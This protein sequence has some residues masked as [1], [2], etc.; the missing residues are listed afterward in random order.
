LDGMGYSQED[1]RSGICRL[2]GQMPLTDFAPTEVC[3]EVIET[4]PLGDGIVKE[5]IAYDGDP[6][7][8]ITAYLLRPE[9]VQSSRPAVIV[10]HGHGPYAIGKSS[11]VSEGRTEH[12][13]AFGLVRRGFVVLAPDFLC[14]EDRSCGDPT[15]Y[16]S[17]QA[18]ALNLFLKGRSL[19]G[20]WVWDA[21]RGVSALSAMPYVDAARIGSIGH[22]MGG[23]TTILLMAVDGR[24][25]A[26]VTSC[27]FS[28]WDALFAAGR[29]FAWA[30]RMP[31][32]AL[33]HNQQQSPPSWA[34]IIG[35]I[36]PR[37]L[38]A[39]T[40]KWDPISPFQGVVSEVARARAQYE[41]VG[42]GG[43]LQFLVSD[44]GHEFPRP[45]REKAY[46][47]LE[48]VL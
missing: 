30:R 37:P 31:A 40:G 6:G 24:V 1:T 38:L 14:F 32:L 36:A 12:A 44:C 33:Y 39:H 4:A 17:E 46:E 15:C 18:T 9:P 43:N 16:V 27:G 35:L 8:Q 21:M 47:W 2:L 19:M 5:E 26:G 7:E 48:S 45:E 29:F 42:A 41:S 3:F 10:L 28:S 13:F 23:S 34:S 25:G 22:S 11:I 20:K